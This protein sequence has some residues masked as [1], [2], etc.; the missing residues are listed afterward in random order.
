MEYAGFFVGVCAVLQIDTPAFHFTQFYSVVVFTLHQLEGKR[1]G[2]FLYI[3]CLGD[4][5]Q[6]S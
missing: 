5:L 1:K 3:N 4:F 6:L 2:I